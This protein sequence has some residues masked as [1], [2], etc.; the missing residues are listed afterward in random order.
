MQPRFTVKL[1][2]LQNEGHF[3]KLTSCSD[4]QFISPIV[5]TVKNDQSM[6]MALD[7]KVFN[8]AINKNKYKMPNIEMLIDPIS[9][10]HTNTQNG[11]Q[12]YFST[13]DLKFA[14]SQ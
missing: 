8:K 4:E 9:Q 14:N 3:E 10:H 11:Q 5:I 2:R 1:D 13:I 6:K 7:S 12:A